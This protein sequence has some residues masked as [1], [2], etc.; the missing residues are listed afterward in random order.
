MNVGVTIA[1]VKS[2]QGVQLQHV[3][4]LLGGLALLPALYKRRYGY[5]FA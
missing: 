3:G 5:K 1:S 2:L 4:I